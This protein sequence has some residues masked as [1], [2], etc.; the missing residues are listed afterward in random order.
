MSKITQEKKAAKLKGKAAKTAAAKTAK[1]AKVAE[2]GPTESSISQ[3]PNYGK[4]CTC[5]FYGKPCHKTNEYTHRK[6]EKSCY[7]MKG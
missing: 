4:C 6:A 1:K 7:K 3:M 2:V 5:Q